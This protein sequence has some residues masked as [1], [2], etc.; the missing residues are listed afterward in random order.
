MTMSHVSVLSASIYVCLDRALPLSP[1]HDVG[2][3]VNDEY[4]SFLLITIKSR[5]LHEFVSGQTIQGQPAS[6]ITDH[7]CNENHVIG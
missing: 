3:V 5:T 6:A 4:V 2:A 1:V 7:V